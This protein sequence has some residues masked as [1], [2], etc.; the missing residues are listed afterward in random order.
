MTKQTRTETI[1]ARQ[2]ISKNLKRIRQQR[3]LSQE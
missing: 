2:R 3:E 1:S